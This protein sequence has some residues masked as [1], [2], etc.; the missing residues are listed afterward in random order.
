MCEECKAYGVPC[1]ICEPDPIKT[2]CPECGGEGI[3][4]FDGKGNLMTREKWELLD[5]DERCY[6]RR[7]ILAAKEKL[8]NT[9]K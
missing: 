4:Y 2:E 8:L 1:P 3:I 6:D 5:E 9:N 7:H